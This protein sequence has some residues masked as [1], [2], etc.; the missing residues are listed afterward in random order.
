MDFIVHIPRN[1]FEQMFPENLFDD[2]DQEIDTLS[3]DEIAPEDDPL[4]QDH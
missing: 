1:T 3:R 2:E 4:A